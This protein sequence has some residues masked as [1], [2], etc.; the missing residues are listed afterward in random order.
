[1]TQSRAAVLVWYRTAL[2][3]FD[4]VLWLQAHRSDLGWGIFPQIYS[5]SANG[6]KETDAARCSWLSQ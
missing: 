4:P 2:T 5:N 3:G 1:M 6:R